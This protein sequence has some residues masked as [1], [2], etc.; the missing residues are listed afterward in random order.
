M[1]GGAATG[2]GRAIVRRATAVLVTAGLVLAGCTS[3]P[4]EGGSSGGGSAPSEAKPEPQPISLTLKPRHKATDVAPGEPVTVKATNGTLT[5]VSLVN[6]DGKKVKGKLSADKTT[7]RSAEPLGYGK[8]Y[9]LTAR[10][11]GEDGEKTVKRSTFTTVQ[12]KGQISVSMSVP[13]GQTVGVGMP[14]S[15]QFSAPVPNRKAAERALKITTS[16]DTEGGFYWFNDSWVVWRP[17]EYWEPGTKVTVKANIYGKHLGDGMYGMADVS[18]WMKIGRKLVAVADGKTHRLVV[19]IDGK[20]VKNV[21]QSM[22]KPGNETPEGIYTVMSEHTNYTMDSSTYGV[23]VDSPGGYR[24]TVEIAVRLSNSGIFYHS[25]PWSVW[26]QGSQN[27]SH[28]CINLSTE[29]AR[30]LMNQTK[31]GDIFIV[32]N[33]GGPKLEPTDGWS[34]WQMPWKQW[35]KGSA[36]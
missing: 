23:P 21:P 1:R 11:V 36:D 16:N 29:N 26:A 34:F 3:S 27:V 8:Q 14:I 35:Q 4:Q 18:S 31:P 33:S 25:A 2:R 5:S 7:W 30:W 22:G 24:T 32:R 10:G 28:G 17:K 19:Y 20:R 9:K 12:P 13:E 6:P 15:F